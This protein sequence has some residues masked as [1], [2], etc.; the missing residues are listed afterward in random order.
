MGDHYEPLR[1]CKNLPLL[2][3]SG[4]SVMEVEKVYDENGFDV[5]FPKYHR[6]TGEIFGPDGTTW[7]GF[8]K[9]ETHKD[10]NTK[11]GPRGKTW[12]EEQTELIRAYFGN[13]GQT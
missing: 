7:N 11:I 13:P 8:R 4:D 10:T 9:D 2:D 5:S 1:P 12:R 6:D 3:P